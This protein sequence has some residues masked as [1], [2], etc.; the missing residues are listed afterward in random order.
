MEEVEYAPNFNYKS[1]NLE[2]KTKN[3]RIVIPLLQVAGL[4]LAATFLV[5]DSCIECSSGMY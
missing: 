2:G 1:N 5:V 4:K 3:R